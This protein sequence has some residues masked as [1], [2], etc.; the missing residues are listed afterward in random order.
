M[1]NGTRKPV[2]LKRCAYCGK[3]ME[4]A[5]LKNGYLESASQYNRKKYCNRD[6]MKKAF[7]KDETESVSWSNMHRHAR[8]IIPPANCKICGSATNVDVH[9]KDGNYLNNSPEN[10]QRLCRSCHNLQHRKAASCSICGA[11]VKG[12]GYCERHY[13][14]YKRYGDPMAT[15]Y[16]KAKG[17]H[18]PKN[19]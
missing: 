15:C 12:Y 9:H 17:E 5:K 19:M 8:M 2:E 18:K 3:I 10:L 7:R 1:W 13:Q 14:R 4:I 11:K 16:P 6:C